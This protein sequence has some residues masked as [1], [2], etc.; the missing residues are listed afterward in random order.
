MDA[1]AD[2]PLHVLLSIM[3]LYSSLLEPS[4]TDMYVEYPYLEYPQRQSARPL[5]I[6]VA[7]NLNRTTF[8]LFVCYRVGNNSS[9]KSQ[10]HHHPY[11]IMDDIISY[12]EVT[13]LLD[14]PPSLDPRPNCI[15]LRAWRKYAAK[16]LSQIPHPNYAQHGWSGMVVQPAI[17]YLIN[18]TPFVPRTDPGLTAI[19]PQFALTPAI[20]MIDSQFKVDKNMYKTYANINRALYTLLT[21]CVGRQ[22]QLSSTL[23]LSSWDPSMTIIDILAQLDTTYGKPDAQTTAANGAMYNMPITG[24]QT[25]ES[26]FL[27]IEE[28]QEV[29]ILAD[30][31]YTFKQMINHT[32]RLLRKSN[33]FPIKE[34]DDWEPLPN[35]TWA[36]MKLYFHDAYTRRLNVI[37]LSQTSGQHGYS[38]PNQ[39]EIMAHTVGDDASTTSD[40]T[41]NTIA[42]ATVMNQPDSTLGGTTVCPVLAG[43]MAQLASNQAAMMNHMAALQIAPTHPPMQQITFPQQQFTGSGRGGRGNYRNNN[44]TGGRGYNIPNVGYAPPPAGGFN[45]GANQSGVFGRGRGRRSR[46]NYGTV[47]AAN[48]HLG[49]PPPVGIPV[50]NG[51]TNQ[52]QIVPFGAHTTRTTTPNPTKRYANWNYCF[53]CGFDVADDHTSTTCPV[54]WRKPGHQEGCTRDNIQ[55]YVA[56]GHAPSMVGKHKTQFPQANF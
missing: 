47:A 2:I 39:Y 29:A 24:G 12:D 37:S 36:M 21:K 11:H 18:A 30:D 44:Y 43:A 20:K 49:I 55:Q 56:A 5:I 15:R 16:M 46:R 53:S 45:M 25:P 3:M 42:A 41:Q 31:P 40:G 38:N 17:W 22:Y 9:T 35:K 10:Y 8:D 1:F 4:R 28:C 13:K 19:Y 54:V 51:S 26:L 48:Q 6:T 34:F 23:G 14:N 50:Y 52:Q 32:V 27:R 7:H 33:I